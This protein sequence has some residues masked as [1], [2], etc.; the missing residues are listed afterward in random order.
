MGSHRDGLLRLDLDW[1]TGGKLWLGIIGYRKP[2]QHYE[3]A[4]R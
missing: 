3:Q 4:I 2:V 1:S